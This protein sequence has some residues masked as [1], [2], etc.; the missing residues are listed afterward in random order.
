MAPPSGPFYHNQV[1]RH[2]TEGK[3]ISS[4]RKSPS[5]SI[6]IKELIHSR[7]CDWGL[8]YKRRSYSSEA[9]VSEAKQVG[10]VHVN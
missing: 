5:K 9:I 4:S 8:G 3:D 2:G 7:V 1:Y 6:G 10:R